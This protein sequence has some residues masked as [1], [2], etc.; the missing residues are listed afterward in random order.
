MFNEKNEK[1]INVFKV[2]SIISLVGW[3]FI[4]IFAGIISYDELMLIQHSYAEYRGM[5]ALLDF[6]IPFVACLLIG[7]LN[8]T[9]NMLIIQYLG[10]VQSI[11]DKII[12]EK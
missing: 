5:P 8:Y 1:W 11:R 10:N 4:A 12:E 9:R 3:L 7:F 6:L 2:I